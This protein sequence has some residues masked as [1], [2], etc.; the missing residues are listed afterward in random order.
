VDVSLDAITVRVRQLTE[1]F[2][3]MKLGPERRTGAQPW[4]PSA[5][6]ETAAFIRDLGGL[7]ESRNFTEHELFS[8]LANTCLDMCSVLFSAGASTGVWRDWCSL[9]GRCTYAAG[10]TAPALELLSIARDLEDP[11]IAAELSRAAVDTYSERALRYLLLKGAPPPAGAPV[12]ELDTMHERLVEAVV[13]GST[14]GAEQE[15]TSIARWWL[16]ESEYGEFEPGDFPS[17][18]PEPNAAAAAV[19]IR[20]LHPELHDARV[21]DFLRAGLE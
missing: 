4:L 6:E 1:E 13:S 15:L 7:R 12:D 14:T 9:A 16:A 18:E 8:M 5:A 17:F 10:D 2:P 19:V 21:A 20:G 3:A 11:T